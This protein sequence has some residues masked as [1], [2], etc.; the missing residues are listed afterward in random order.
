MPP[1]DIDRPQPPP[2]RWAGLKE[3]VARRAVL[4]G[5]VLGGLVGLGVGGIILKFIGWRREEA[6]RREDQRILDEWHAE[7]NRKKDEERRWQ[8]QWRT[9]T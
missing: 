3:T 9:G 6:Q 1:A 2:D 8:D 7:E 4:V 5:I